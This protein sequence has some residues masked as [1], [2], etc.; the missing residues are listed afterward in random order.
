MFVELTNEVDA[1]LR[2]LEEKVTT[3]EGVITVKDAEIAE[4]SKKVVSMVEPLPLNDDHESK[5][6]CA[7]LEQPMDVNMFGSGDMDMERAGG[8][9]PMKTEDFAIDASGSNLRE[10]SFF[11]D[12]VVN[13]WDELKQVGEGLPLRESVRAFI[14]HLRREF[15]FP[16]KTYERMTFMLNNNSDN[17]RPDDEV[18]KMLVLCTIVVP[19]KLKNESNEEGKKYKTSSTTIQQDK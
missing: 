7:G 5:M 12:F 4:L 11:K 9:M 8:L 1:M 14:E 10:L 16:D 2:K 6:A 3:L 18:V 19:R 13:E 17:I 15:K